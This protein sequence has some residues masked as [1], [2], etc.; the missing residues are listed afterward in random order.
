MIHF[1][2]QGHSIFALLPIALI[3]LVA[4]SAEPG[5]NAELTDSAQE[6]LSTTIG[7]FEFR[8]CAV[9][10]GSCS[11]GPF[12][13]LV[14]YGA[15][16]GWAFAFA[17][18]NFNCNNTTFGDPKRHAAKACYYAPY[19]Y[20]GSEG[21]LLPDIA[22]NYGFGPNATNPADVFQQTTTSVRLRCD[23]NTFGDPGGQS[24]DCVMA[25]PEYDYVTTEGSIFGVGA[26]TPI[27][28]GANGAF[29][30]A[31]LSGAQ[32]CSNATF[33]S[34]PAPHVQ[35]SCYRLRYPLLADED[36]SFS[37]PT[38]PNGYTV[39]Y[40]TGTDGNY[41][42][43]HLQSGTCSNETFGGDP[44]PHAVKHC[45]GSETRTTGLNFP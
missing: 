34:D 44:Q 10:D 11:M 40:G 43:A 45:Y 13:R 31:I 14:A 30:Y 28:Y 6:A 42:A 3:G 38:T 20:V 29:R 12:P 1:S 22:N 15:T 23:V 7:S 26:S 18:N 8:Q 25:L 37:I 4:C 39:Y 36:Q 33:G 9:E 21:D 5:Q 35:K 16:G 2:G 27:A 19:I 17:G 41:L 32:R 24:R